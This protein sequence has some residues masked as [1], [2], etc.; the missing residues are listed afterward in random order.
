[1]TLLIMKPS[2][3]SPL[4]CKEGLRAMLIRDEEARRVQKCPSL[5]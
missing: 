2:P 1:M 3:P 4:F 5:K